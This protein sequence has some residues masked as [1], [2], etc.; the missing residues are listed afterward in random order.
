MTASDD[1]LYLSPPIP[2]EN[3]WIDY[4]GHLNMAY[5]NVVFDQAIDLAL[6]QA[7]LGPE[8]LKR[9]GFTYVALEAHI[10]YLKEV[11]LTDTVRVSVQVLD[12]DAKR[13]HLFCEMRHADGSVAATSEWICVNIDAAKRRSAPWPDEV[14][15]ALDSMRQ[16]KADS[17]WPERAGRSIGM[18]RRS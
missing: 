13:L 6:V 9:T 7:G 10:C 17:P 12:L 4:N 15:A 16:A 2:I 5:Y 1:K 8:Y 14:H 3:G 18:P 11:L